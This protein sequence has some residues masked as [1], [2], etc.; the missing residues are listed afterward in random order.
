MD[1]ESISYTA[2]SVKND[3]FKF[4]RMPFGLA[5]APKTFQQA[6]DTLFWRLSYVKVYIDYI[7]ILSENETEHYEHLENVLKIF[8]DHGMSIN[9]DKCEFLRKR[10][11]FLG[12]LISEYSISQLSTK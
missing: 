5:N 6:I 7:M 1:E 4:I 3:K 8:K 9:F 12:H 2:F 10:V 11:K